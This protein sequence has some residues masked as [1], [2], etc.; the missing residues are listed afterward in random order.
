VTAQNSAGIGAAEP[1][2]TAPL[3]YKIADLA[4]K[5]GLLR[6]SRREI[7]KQIEQG[8]LK[9][10][11]QGRATLVTAAALDEYVKLLVREAEPPR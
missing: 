9:V 1:R 10:V 5:N 6:L 4:G 3:V 7:Y 2:T 11:K 8:R